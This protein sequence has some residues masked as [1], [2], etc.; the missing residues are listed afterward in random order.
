L[1]KC[2]K[3]IA[4]STEK[5]VRETAG[6]KAGAAPS[7]LLSILVCMMVA[8]SCLSSYFVVGQKRVKNASKAR[9]CAVY[10]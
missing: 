8:G 6:L 1:S 5:A 7:A 4:P 10:R 2:A 9:G 3:L